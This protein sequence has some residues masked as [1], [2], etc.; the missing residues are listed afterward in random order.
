M[1]P[2]PD[3]LSNLIP[4]F[5]LGNERDEKCCFIQ[6]PQEFCNIRG[7]DFIGQNYRF[8]YKVVL[9]AY[10]GFELGVPCCGTN[11]LFDR[12]H[13]TKIGGI[14]YGSITE[15]FNT[16]LLL[17]S[18]GLHSRY[19]PKKTAL[20]FAPSNFIDF[21]HQRQRW[22]IGGLQ[23]VFNRNYFSKFIKLPYIY[24]WIYTFSGSTPILSFFLLFLL[25]GPIIDLLKGKIFL[26]GMPYNLYLIRFIPYSAIYVFYLLLLH[27]NLS[28]PIFILSLQESIFMIPFYIQFFFTF[29]FRICGIK[30]FTF[31]ITP[32]DMS[33][34]NN[35]DDNFKSILLLLPIFLY[36]CLSTFSII[37]TKNPE[38]SMAIDIG[39]IVFIS[40][41]L[42]N[43]ILS[44]LQTCILSY[45]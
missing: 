41:Q 17:H 26:C 34:R 14:Q 1:A 25:F 21:F 5:Y 24:R 42:L 22:S 13:L 31:T 43:P 23:I 36:I 44:L 20:G 39:W 27:R 8:F 15:D 37:F 12:Y 11:V 33:Y 6:S 32:K 35:I 2:L 38:K 10:G 30:R 45:F 40:A 16:S 18:M 9:R 29:L 4:M 19:F 28:W 7:I 3:I